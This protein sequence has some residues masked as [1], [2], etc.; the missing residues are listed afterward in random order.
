MWLNLGFREHA[1]ETLGVPSRER[2]AFPSHRHGDKECC[3]D[4]DR[5]QAG[6]SK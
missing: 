3:E 5:L 1:R 6:H 2:T 4:R